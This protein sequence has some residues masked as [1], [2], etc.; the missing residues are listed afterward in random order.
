MTRILE[1]LY[2]WLSFVPRITARNILEIIIITF[3]VYEILF[4]I[5][6]TRAWTLLKGIVV[7]LAFSV[8]AYLLQLKSD[9]SHVVL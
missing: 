8:L 2:S 9:R 1:G 3:L 7:I 6:N 4:W 5:K